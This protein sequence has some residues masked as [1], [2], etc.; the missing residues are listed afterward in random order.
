[1]PSASVPARPVAS[2]TISSSVSQSV[3]P[4][5]SPAQ[6]AGLREQLEEQRRFRL[7]QLSELHDVDPE[8]RGEVSTLL[9]IGA[10]AALADVRS[11]LR[12]MD[13]GSYGRCTDCGAA[14]PLDRL[15]VLPQVGQC[16]ECR[17]ATG[18]RR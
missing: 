8:Q 3:T 13:L 5:V 7:A 10:R 16:L 15:E 4:S 14:L 1:M 12:R 18:G 17:A 11:A 9:V 6:L 2:A